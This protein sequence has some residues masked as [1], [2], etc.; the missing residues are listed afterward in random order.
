M[1]LEIAFSMAF[2]AQAMHRLCTGY[3]D[4]LH[5]IYRYFDRF[6]ATAGLFLTGTEFAIIKIPYKE[7]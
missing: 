2:H 6:K 5:R 7:F 3:A 4:R 1:L